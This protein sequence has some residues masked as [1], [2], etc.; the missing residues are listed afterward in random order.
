MHRSESQTAACRLYDVLATQEKRIV[1]AESCTGGRVAATLCELPGVS[2]YLC[3]SFVVYRSGSKQAWLGIPAHVLDDPDV[4]PVSPEASRLLATAA[5]QATPEADIAL[6]ITGDIGPG[7]PS[8]TDATAFLAIALRHGTSHEQT[9]RLSPGFPADAT[10]DTNVLIRTQRLGHAT[11]T[12]LNFAADVLE[13][14][15]D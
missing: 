2:S 3:G 9:V 5:L 7:A 1:F 15:D 10:R 12:A 4:G 8:R 6:A 14:R 11:T 13:H